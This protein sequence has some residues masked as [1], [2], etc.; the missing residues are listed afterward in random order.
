MKNIYKLLTL[1]LTLTII[2]SCERD[3]GEYPYL[4]RDITIGFRGASGSLL[5]EN[6]AS[7]IVSATVGASTLVNSDATVSV[8]VDDSSTAVLGVD[9]DFVAGQDVT[10]ASGNLL[11][12]IDIVAD[13]ENSTVEGKTVVLNL[14]SNDPSLMVSEAF[15]QYT[16]TLIQFCPINADF[17]GS[18]TLSTTATGIFDS[19]VF[20]N[21]AVT[22]DM[23]T[24]PT[25][26]V[27]SVSPY[28]EFGAFAPIDFAFSLVCGNV[29][30]PTGQVTGVGCGSSTT[31]GPAATAGT[32]DSSDDSSF[33]IVISD[34]EG[35]SCGP[36]YEAAFTLT[37]N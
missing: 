30:V 34:D 20:L 19:V 36:A 32:Y 15:S 35:G 5:V 24:E 22:I 21:G 16:I 3:Q 29:I 6:G 8:S 26:R 25:D 13:F 1:A 7:N 23:G 4:D 11:T 12:N 37:K 28:P 17:T 31:I 33:T 2:T 9:Y 10:L 18:Y 14:I 27:M